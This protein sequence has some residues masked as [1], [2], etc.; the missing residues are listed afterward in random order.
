[1]A[2]PNSLL[3]AVFILFFYFE[4]LFP[5][6]ALNISAFFFNLCETGVMAN[7]VATIMDKYFLILFD[8]LTNFLFTASETKS[9]Y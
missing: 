3:V 7:T 2:E 5:S 8:T 4:T 9:D 6:T 1:M